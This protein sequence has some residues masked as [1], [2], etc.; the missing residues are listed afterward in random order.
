[1]NI[2]LEYSKIC[3]I[4]AEFEKVK[5]VSSMRR[6]DETKSLRYTIE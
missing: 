5:A 4:E 6:V 3:K 2:A 1:M